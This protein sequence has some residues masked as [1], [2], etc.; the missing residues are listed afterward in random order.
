M[1]CVVLQGV[2]ALVAPKLEVNDLRSTIDPYQH[3][4]T[5]LTCTLPAPRTSN[6]T[7]RNPRSGSKTTA[8]FTLSK[9]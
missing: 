3:A 7:G 4:V 5:S 9:L 6:Q 1:L 2:L 8:T